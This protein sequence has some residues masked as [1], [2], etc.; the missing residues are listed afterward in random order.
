MTELLGIYIAY[1]QALP[2]NEM[3]G[4]ISQHVNKR[5]R[6]VIAV[7][8]KFTYI[9]S[10]LFPCFIP[11]NCNHLPS[12]KLDHQIHHFQIQSHHHE[13]TLIHPLTIHQTSCV[14]SHRW[15]LLLMANTKHSFSAQVPI[16]CFFIFFFIAFNLWALH[17]TSSMI[18]ARNPL[19]RCTSWFICPPAAMLI[20]SWD[21]IQA[22]LFHRQRSLY[23]R[24]LRIFALSPSTSAWYDDIL[25][26]IKMGTAKLNLCVLFIGFAPY[27]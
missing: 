21:L 26:I 19:R 7:V 3:D 25:L 10:H 14:P 9:F 15:S 22:M 5:I 17:N 12:L 13:M 4:T 8:N 6:T 27:R 20:L 11:I 16:F 1:K 2:Y 18:I 24:F 23:L